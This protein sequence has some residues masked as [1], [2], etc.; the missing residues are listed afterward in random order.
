VTDPAD[1]YAERLR[2]AWGFA[3]WERVEHTLAE[4]HDRLLERLA[5][6][7][8]ERWLDVG[9][10]TGAVAVRAA[11]AGADVTG[12]DLAEPLVETARE[13]ARREGLA[14]RF[15]AG[16][17]EELPFE[18]GEFH[19]VASSMGLIFAPRHVRAA[20]EVARVM[21][22]GGKLGFT[23]WRPGA[24]FSPVIERY[25]PPLP[26]GVDD[27]E[28][29]GREEHVRELLGDAFDLEFTDERTAFTGRSGEE[30]WE[31]YST[32]L[33]PFKAL[34]RSVGPDVAELLRADFVDFLERHRVNGGIR[35]E[36][37]YLLV[38]GRRR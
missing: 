5:P 12:L 2:A 13:R 28:E 14:I 30:M 24:A 15:E 25:R 38:L 17:V 23:A 26:P 20:S 1:E 11:R 6:K 34:I 37:D 18:D 4:V 31:L 3:P 10:G 19:T 16:S 7:P 9:T 33:G 22:P 29:W 35:L 8:G 21:Q 27:P 36:A 32:S